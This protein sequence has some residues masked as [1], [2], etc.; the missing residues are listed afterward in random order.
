MHNVIV[1]CFVVRC[2]IYMHN[3]HINQKFDLILA[4]YKNQGY[5]NVH[6]FKGII[7]MS[8]LCD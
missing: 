2:T 3:R 6:T 1:V 4:L 5:K 7:I 8:K